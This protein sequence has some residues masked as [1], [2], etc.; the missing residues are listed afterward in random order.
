MLK[1]SKISEK[2]FLW[3]FLLFII[4]LLFFKDAISG[5]K[6]LYLRDVGFL[7]FPYKTIIANIIHRGIFPFWNPYMNCGEPILSNPQYMLF[8][9][10][11]FFYYI[12][13]SFCFFQIHFLIHILIGAFGFY[14]FINHHL[15]N[16]PI[17]FISSFV[18]GFNTFALSH[19]LFQNL[20][21][22]LALIPW[23]LILLRKVKYEGKNIYVVLTSIL[24]SLLIFG[25]EPFY[26]LSTILISMLYFFRERFFIGYKKSLL[27]FLLFFLFSSIQIIPTYL[28]IKEFNVKRTIQ[29]IGFHS[30]LNTFSDITSGKKDLVP[31]TKSQIKGNENFFYFSTYL[32]IVFLLISFFG[33]LNIKNKEKFFS[34]LT[35]FLLALISTG[36]FLYK[37][38]LK[39]PLLNYG[40]FPIKFL[41]P[42][43]FILVFYFSL[44]LKDLLE[45][46]SLK[47]FNIASIP[48]FIITIALYLITKRVNII[49]ELITILLLI[50]IL[51]LFKKR[52]NLIIVSI[53][54]IF[55]GVYILHFP[56]SIFTK[57]HYFT[58]KP[59]FLSCLNK[60]ELKKYRFS[61]DFKLKINTSIRT[62]NFRNE[63]Y[64]N[65]LGRNFSSSIFG[66]RQGFFLK[67]GAFGSKNSILITNTL[68]KGDIP[69]NYYLNFF[70]H[71]GV[72][73]LISPFKYNLK[74]KCCYTIGDNIKV[75]I[76]D[77]KSQPIYHFV[78]IL[79]T[80]EKGKI[81]KNLF[82]WNFNDN[83]AV[84]IPKKRENNIFKNIEFTQGEI[85]YHK[86]NI[87]KK[88]FKLKSK[89][90]S[91]FV[92]EEVYYP[93]WEIFLDGRKV[94]N[95]RVN[96]IFQ[97]C[98]VPRGGHTITFKY[99]PPGW[100]L[101]KILFL[102]G[103]ILS[104]FFVIKD[105][106]QKI[107]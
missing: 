104:I 52:K 19:L 98:I 105:V 8:Y 42:L 88:I 11:Y 96:G 91:F 26:F 22:Y 36:G 21:V 97:G 107:F 65:E 47:L 23:I 43:F 27:I 76:Y 35:I 32:G 82:L 29:E 83:V 2:N 16:K 38:L 94:K 80:E 58:T 55:I 106:R 28:T 39:I 92:Y 9:P 37:V 24:F 20:V 90:L 74:R 51:N 93:G 44:G 33:I 4:W 10:T 89:G 86:D 72:K 6:F 71:T 95:F 70:R 54:L 60:S 73:F 3:L 31:G 50:V 67:V 48:F 77:L 81:I 14:F 85:I 84:L 5:K 69:L 59:K 1:R 56:E 100:R 57:N 46:K 17:S 63:Y 7:Y 102:I 13:K 66:A 87:N 53:F 99:T 34:L 30:D 79:K 64:K 25:V 68:L 75:F 18:Y 15:K 41:F 101:S 103:L 61:P 62:K 12:F 40:R 45:E 49:F 78:R